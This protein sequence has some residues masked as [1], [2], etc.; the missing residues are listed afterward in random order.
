MSNHEIRNA[1]TVAAVKLEWIKWWLERKNRFRCWRGGKQRFW[2]INYSGARR[3]ARWT[4]RQ[5]DEAQKET[6]KEKAEK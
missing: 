3:L 4:V 6:K 2:I 1:A 5:S